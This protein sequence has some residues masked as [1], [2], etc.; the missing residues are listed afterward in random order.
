[1]DIHNAKYLKI[2]EITNY[3]HSLHVLT[4]CLLN[5]SH[6][7]LKYDVELLSNTQNDHD[8]EHL[9]SH[10]NNIMN[11]KLSSYIDI[12]YLRLD[13]YKTDKYKDISHGE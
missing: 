12:Y 8:P 10:D 9:W 5:Y 4:E 3:R 11:T 7:F 6:N 1:M 2:K 13:T